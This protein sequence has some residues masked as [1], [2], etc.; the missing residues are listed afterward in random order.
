MKKWW[1]VAMAALVLGGCGG[2]LSVKRVDTDTEVALTDRWN[3]ED[4]RLVSE[5][6]IE[7]MLTF[8]WLRDFS[9]EH[10]DRRPVIVIQRV[11]NKSH[12]HIATDTFINDLKRALMRSGRADFIVGG[13]ERSDVREELRGQDLYASEESRK[14]MGEEL[15]ADFA[16]SGTITSIVDQFKGSKVIFYQ[17][18]LK[19]IDLQS[20]REVWSGQKKL[21]KVSERSR[22]GL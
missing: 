16:L 18:D 14:E 17:V 5:A 10:P 6:M 13:K 20:T 12:E 4:S 11:R 7:D 15:G 2:G 22:F 9:D 21:K 3:D 1:I 19:L 8:P